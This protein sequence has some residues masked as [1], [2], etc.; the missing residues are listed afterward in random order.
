[1]NLSV[2]DF[3][4]HFSQNW[5]KKQILAKKKSTEEFFAKK[6]KRSAEKST[7]KQVLFKS[8]LYEACM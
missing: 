5:G 8:T 4:T 1:M 2:Y 3:R 7:K 6:K